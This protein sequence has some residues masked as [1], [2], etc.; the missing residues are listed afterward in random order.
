MPGQEAVP[1]E[2]KLHKKASDSRKGLLAFV[3]ATVTVGVTG[4]VVFG[5]KRRVKNAV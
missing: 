5:L 3:A 1:L 2:V 4:D